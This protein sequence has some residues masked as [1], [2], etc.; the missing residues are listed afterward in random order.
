M[1]CISVQ[2]LRSWGHHLTILIIQSFQ[3]PLSFCTAETDLEPLACTGHCGMQ[4][5]SSCSMHSV[6][7]AL[8][9]S[10]SMWDFGSLRPR[11]NLGPLHWD[12]GLIHWTTKQVL[13]IGDFTFES[14]YFNDGILAISK[15]C[16]FGWLF[17]FTWPLVMSGNQNVGFLQLSGMYVYPKHTLRNKG[18]KQTL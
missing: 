5:F 14:S 4:A 16:R 3:D 11:L 9:L 15:I 13:K 18:G 1:F 6:V 2:Q 12:R 8:G 17:K 10:C 7:V